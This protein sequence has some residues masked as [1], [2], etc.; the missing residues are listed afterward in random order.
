MQDRG[1]MP[2]HIRA[3]LEAKGYYRL[4]RAERIR[5]NNACFDA[6]FGSSK[7]DPKVEAKVLKEIRGKL[8]D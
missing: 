2:A 5:L 6:I 1:R 3:R 7:G 4:S 8:D